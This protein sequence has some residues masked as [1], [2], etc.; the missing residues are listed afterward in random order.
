MLCSTCKMARASPLMIRAAL[1]RWTCWTRPPPKRILFWLN[2]GQSPW[3]TFSTR[4]IFRPPCTARIHRSN[5]PCL[6]S[7][8]SQVWAIYMCARRCFGRVFRQNTVPVRYLRAVSR[9]WFPSSVMSLPRRSKQA[10]PACVIIVRPMASWAIFNTVLMY[11][12]A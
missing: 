4:L 2:S 12:T 11:M 10:G 9:P 3:A 5:R 8:S 6:I 1:V 7:E